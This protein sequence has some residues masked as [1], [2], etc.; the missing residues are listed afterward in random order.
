MSKIRL[1]EILEN[2]NKEI[3]N[4]KKREPIVVLERKI[5]RSL[6]IRDFKGA[7]YRC[8]GSIGIIAEVKAKSPSENIITKTDPLE[9]AKEYEESKAVAISVLT[10][11]LYFGGSLALME[12]VKRQTNKPILRKD[13]IMDE[14]QIYQSRAY[15][16]DAIL[17]ISSILSKEK[18]SKFIK[19]S[20]KLG[21]EC[22]V[23]LH[24][25][26]DLKIIP[27]E[28]EIYGINN[29]SLLNG[30]KTDLNVTF[31]LIKYIPKGK[32]I[33][34][35]S[36][37]NGPEDTKRLKD[38]GVNGVL[39]GTSILKTLKE[40]QGYSPQKAIDFLLSLSSN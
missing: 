10:D 30:F 4:W 15:G 35:E 19:I 20:K 9:I 7:F 36:G 40:S 5:A 21:M 39:T 24:L 1:K 32:L 23:E 31:N 38:V 34:S 14:Y 27:K 28:T 11:E 16:A 17:L 3:E 33:I 25:K 22:L 13:F 12:K 26:E 2:K 29:R 8:R 6:P 18:L 37:I